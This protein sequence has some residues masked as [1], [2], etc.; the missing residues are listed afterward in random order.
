M[1]QL[2]EDPR[3]PNQLT[4]DVGGDGMPELEGEPLVEYLSTLLLAALALKVK[5]DPL[6]NV[7]LE[8]AGDVLLPQEVHNLLDL[9]IPLLRRLAHLS[10]KTLYLA[11]D[12]CKDG[13][14]RPHEEDTEEPLRSVC[15]SDV[16]EAYSGEDGVYEVETDKPLLRE[17]LHVD[18]VCLLKHYELIL[19][20]EGL[21]DKPE[22]AREKVDGEDEGCD[23]L[24]DAQDGRGYADYALKDVENL[25]HLD[26]AEETDEA[27]GLENP[28]DLDVIHVPPRVIRRL[29]RLGVA[30]QEDF[31]EGPGGG[32]GG[33]DVE[34]E[35][36]LDVELGTLPPIV[37]IVALV[38]STDEEEDYDLEDEK[39]VN[40]HVHPQPREV[41]FT[42]VL[43]PQEP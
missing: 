16:A 37:D 9:L 19:L 28:E 4:V 35:P 43:S 23:E 15:A 10:S 18:I 33:E 26:Q 22:A 5:L 41:C 3:V 20:G 36:A 31:V 39:E 21:L 2:S 11:D 12:C 8:P 30:R 1:L 24:A 32:D 40:R 13:C 42:Y 25:E 14:P 7:L 29:V 38:R 17:R 34:G 27:E 6:Y